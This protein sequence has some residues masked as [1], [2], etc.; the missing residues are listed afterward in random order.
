M[1]AY[2]THHCGDLRAADIGRTVKLSGWIHRK[3]DHGGVLFIDLRDTYGLTQCVVDQDSPLLAEIEGWR[4]RA[5]V[6]VDR[7]RQGA[8]RRH[9]ERQDGDRR[10]RALYRRRP[11]CNPPPTSCR[12]RSRTRTDGAGEDIRLKYRFLDLRR[13]GMHS[14][15][16]LRNDVIRRCAAACGTRLPGIQHPHPDRQ[17]PRG[18]ARL[19]RPLAPAPRQV[20]RPA[21]G[22]AAVQA[23]ADGRPA[24]TATSRSRPASATRTAAPTAWPN[25]T[26]STSK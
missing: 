1:H 11:P 13:E 19:P 17:Q 23:A 14:R 18:R 16:R 24:S 3:R 21:P 10:R 25:S 8:P 12:C 6:T 15:V 4:P 2:R 20:L 22:A 5:V 7:P 26:S 9:R